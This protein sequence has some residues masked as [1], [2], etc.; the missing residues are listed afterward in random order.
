[1]KSTKIF[2][3]AKVFSTFRENVNTFDHYGVDEL[4]GSIG[5]SVHKEYRRRGIAQ[6]FLQSRSIICNEFGIKLTSTLF[7]SDALNR[8]ADQVGFELDKIIR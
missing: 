2:D 5:L 6:Q 1:M 7:T 8:V 4:L 3:Y